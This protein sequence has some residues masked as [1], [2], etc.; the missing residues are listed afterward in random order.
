MIHEYQVITIDNVWKW[1]RG[2]SLS[3]ACKRAGYSVADV[4][5]VVKIDNEWYCTE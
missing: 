3:D 4:K 5:Q 2:D 1:F